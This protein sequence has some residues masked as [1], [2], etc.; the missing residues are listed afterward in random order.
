NDLVN[1]SGDLL[2]DGTINVS[3][4]AGGDFG[5]G[6]YRV[7]NYGGALIDNGLELGTLPDGSSAGVQ[8][9][10]AGQVNLVNSAGLMLNFW[11]GAAGSKNDGVINGGDGVWQNRVGNDNWT[12]ANGTVN[13]PYTDDAFAV[14]S[15]ASGTVKVDN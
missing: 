5:A 10:I 6:V 8:T 11:D 7:F 4:P 12:N 9:S 15:G 13:A 1:V 2:L 14:F 3:V